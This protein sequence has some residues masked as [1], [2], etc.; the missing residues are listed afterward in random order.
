MMLSLGL[1]RE[2]RLD[3]RNS[4]FM[5]IEYSLSNQHTNFTGFANLWVQYHDFQDNYSFEKRVCAQKKPLWLME[6]DG[7]LK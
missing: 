2:Y 3:I 1:D 6:R 7:L 4:P 5:P